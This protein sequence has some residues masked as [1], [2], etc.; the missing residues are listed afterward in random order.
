MKSHYLAKKWGGGGGGLAGPESIPPTQYR[1][2][3]T[4]RHCQGNI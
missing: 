4:P 1:Y 2:Q 3:I